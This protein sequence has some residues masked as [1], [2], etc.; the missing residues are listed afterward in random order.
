[1]L[2]DD[3]K[4]LLRDRTCQLL[5]DEGM[6]IENEEITSVLL[7]KGCEEAPSGRIRIPKELIEEM[8]E[9]QKKTQEQDEQDQELHFQCGIDWAHHIIWNN[10]QQQM[11]DNLQSQ[12]LMSAFDCGPTTYYDYQQAKTTAVNTE[13]FIEMKKFAQAT[14]EIGYISTWWRC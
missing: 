14:P 5:W 13:I 1:M 7:K 9:Y 3:Q 2:S 8:A 12:L 10:Q 11:R 4:E 6:K